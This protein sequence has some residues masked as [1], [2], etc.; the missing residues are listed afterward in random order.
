MLIAAESRPTKSYVPRSD[1]HLSVEK[2]KQLWLARILYNWSI[3]KKTGGLAQ[4][5]VKA[6]SVGE[7][8]THYGETDYTEH[9]IFMG[10]TTDAVI[11]DLKGLER[12]A[13]H[14]EYLDEPWNHSVS[15]HT[16]L[17]IAHEAVR[18]GLKRKGFEWT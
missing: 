9:D 1:D 5:K 10:K 3:W 8:F 16:V 12:D 17:A 13:I 4:F 6:G 2:R 11:R 7:G 18:L 14:C 15:V